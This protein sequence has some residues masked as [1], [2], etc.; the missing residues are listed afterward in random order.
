M[1]GTCLY[2]WQTDASEPTL[3]CIWRSSDYIERAIFIALALMLAHTL[4][5]VGRFSFRHYKYFRCSAPMFVPDATR[6]SQ[7]NHRRIVAG[8][9]QGLGT[10]KAISAMAPFLGLAG[11]CYGI[12]AALT[13]GGSISK[14]SLLALVT[15]R[16]GTAFISTAAGILVAIPAVI[17]HNFMRTRVEAFLSHPLFAIACQDD[18]DGVGSFHFAQR[19]PLQRR[20]SSL[21]PFAL[22][23]APALAC[24][25]AL[26]TPFHPYRVPTG[27]A[28]RLP[29]NTCEHGDFPDRIIVLRVTKEGTLFLNMEPENWEGLPQRLSDIYRMRKERVLY[30]RA[31][32]EVLFQTVAEAIDLTRTSVRANSE[33]LDI[34]VRLVTPAI[35]EESRACY[36]H[37]WNGPGLR[38]R[39]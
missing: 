32:D 1:P 27:L 15:S 2:S 6:A 28:V 8:L 5:V 3:A 16:I 23:A 33:P 39:K 11:T 24:V 17:S 26:F 31:D 20:F 35:E 29:Q 19:L 10:L 37:L 21:P 9:S 30:F 18:N 38:I 34:Y 22:I 14:A 13:F 7:R 36:E 4:F 25:V 12:L